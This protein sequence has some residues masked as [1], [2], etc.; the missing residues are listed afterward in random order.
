MLAQCDE[1][2]D[3]VTTRYDV[4]KY[5]VVAVWGVENDYGWIFDKRSLPASLS[6]LPFYEYR[7]SF[8]QGE[9]LATLELL[10]A[11]DIR[12][13][14]IA[15]SWVEVLDHTQFVPSTY[16]RIAMNFDGDGYCDLVNSVLDTLGSTA[17]YLKKVD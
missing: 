1:L 4:D 9:F 2:L 7:Q 16:T 14:G 11:G 15:D 12:D 8:F 13:A 3:Q 6:T 5:M 10:W 17:D